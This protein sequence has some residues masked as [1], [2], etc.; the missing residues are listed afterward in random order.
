MWP[1][2][3]NSRALIFER[4]CLNQE[5]T[6]IL[7]ATENPTRKLCLKYFEVCGAYKSFWG[8]LE[9]SNHLRA[10]GFLKKKNY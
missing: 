10:K 5:I 2:I 7:G 6:E 3:G 8:D 1:A 9:K 4:E